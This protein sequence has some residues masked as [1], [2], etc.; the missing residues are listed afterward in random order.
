[1]DRPA[2]E[3]IAVPVAAVDAIWEQ[4][5]PHL[6]AAIGDAH[7][8]Y[9]PDDIRGFCR[10]G[11]MKLFIASEGEAVVAAVV[12]EIVQYPRKRV[13]VVPFAGGAEIGRWY[14][15]MEACVEEWARAFG[16]SGE[17]TFGRKGWAR[18]TGAEEI[19]VVLWREFSATP[20]SMEVH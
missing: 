8:R 1:M 13:L 6:Q 10:G 14:A 16:C 20:T 2:L 19:G 3:I 17:M 18:I 11:N 12:G 9:T 4:A 7:G 15:P 5:L